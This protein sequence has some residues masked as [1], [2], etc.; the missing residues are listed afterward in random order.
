MRQDGNGGFAMLKKD[1]I[2]YMTNSAFYLRGEE[3]RKSV[4]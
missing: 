2:R 3:D 4:V 1:D